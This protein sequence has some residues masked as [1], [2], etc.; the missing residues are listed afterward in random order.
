MLYFINELSNDF[1]G[2]C[3]EIWD[4]INLKAEKY[5]FT[6]QVSG[7]SASGVINKSGGL[8]SGTGYHKTFSV[9]AGNAYIIGGYVYDANS[10][11]LYLLYNNDTLV[12]YYL[13]DSS[14][15]VTNKKIIIPTGV[16][17]III[18]GN[19]ENNIYLTLGEEI[20]FVDADQI[21]DIDLDINYKMDKLFSYDTNISITTE[22]G[23]LTKGGSLYADTGYHASINVIPGEIY[24]INGY[25]YDTNGF[26][27]YILYNNTTLVSAVTVGASYTIQSAV[28]KVPNGVNKISINANTAANIIAKKGTEVSQNI[29]K[30]GVIGD[31]IS[32]GHGYAGGYIRCISELYGDIS[33]Y[34]N[35]AANGATIASGTTG[36]SGETPVVI[37][38]MIDSLD[39]DCQYIA[40]SGGINDYWD[41]VP[42]GVG[43]TDIV[44]GTPNQNTFYGALDVMFR[45]AINTF[46][47]KK[48][49]YVITHK[50]SATYKVENEL[51]LTFESYREAIID[52]C[53]FY[54]IPYIDLYTTAHFNT[55]ISAYQHAYT[56]NSDTVHPNE[57]G[58]KTFYAP[59]IHS[60]MKSL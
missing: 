39:S 4:A 45:K 12:D 38:N 37:S 33:S 47:G 18:N 14:Y 27:L 21:D 29:G 46:I 41:N 51:G 50:I 34:Q 30:V 48:L 8:Y 35:I 1:S 54:G 32:Y 16:N 20:N 11:P 7:T 60:F 42:L 49:F 43:M 58:Y 25:Q 19:T 22:S 15:T 55:A 40:M 59:K 10:F 53:E 23:L 24:L 44:S 6:T 3:N 26:P 17:K 9:V 31:S 5:K 2:E 56:N 52:R 57:L 28:V 36:A 13:F